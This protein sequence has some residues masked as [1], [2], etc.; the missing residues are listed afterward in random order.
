MLRAIERVLARSVDSGAI[1]PHD[2][3]AIGMPSALEG[4]MP[5]GVRVEGAML[6]VGAARWLIEQAVLGRDIPGSTLARSQRHLALAGGYVA[7]ASEIELS[8]RLAAM[9]RE[10]ALRGAPHT[11][12]PA[13]REAP[14]HP[15]IECVNC[16]RCTCQAPTSSSECELC[17]RIS[18][19][20][21]HAD[22][23]IARYK[24]QVANGHV[25]AV[26]AS[27][28]HRWDCRSLPSVDS[29]LSML[30][31]NIRHARKQKDDNAARHIAWQR[32]PVLFTAKELR[33]K[34]TRKRG[35]G[36]CSPDLL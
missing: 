4:S 2:Q 31:C 27:R 21:R 25:Y 29:C 7:T 11:G 16:G 9:V 17:Q 22:E 6:A 24:D 15:C 1:E 5:G 19:V 33:M 28:L 20:R 30:E 34:K 10:N 12:Q 26:T 13:A 3:Q 23:D 36:I 32:L 18:R 8:A 35:C 14:Q